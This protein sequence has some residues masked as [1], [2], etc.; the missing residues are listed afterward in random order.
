[1]NVS[2]ELQRIKQEVSLETYVNNHLPKDKHGKPVCPY[3]SSGKSGKANSDSAFS[4]MPS[5]DRFKCFS[6]ET[7]GDIYDLVAQVEHIDVN[8][9]R[10]QLEAI[11]REFNIPLENNSS[12]SVVKPKAPKTQVPQQQPTPT[13][14]TQGRNK[15]HDH[16]QTCI[17]N[18][19]TGKYPEAYEY[20]QGRGFNPE[21]C[22]GLIGYDPRKKSMVIP[23]GD[24]SYYYVERYLYPEQ[25]NGQKHSKPS[26]SLVGEQPI[27]NAK[28]ISEKQPQTL[29]LV[30]G[31]FD[32]LSLLALGHENVICLGGVNNKEKVIKFISELP[33]VPGVL[34]TLDNDDTGTKHTAEAIEQLTEL[35]IPYKVVDYSFIGAKDPNEAFIVNENALSSALIESKTQLLA[36]LNKTTEELLT[37]ALEGLCVST[38]H[39][40]LERILTLGDIDTPIPTGFPSLDEVLDGGLVR[41]LY[42]LGALSS[43][44]KT[45]LLVQIADNIARQGRPVLF[46]TIE[47]SAREIILK[48]LSRLLSSQGVVK[49]GTEINRLKTRYEF[50]DEENRA[51]EEA[52]NTYYQKIAPYMNVLEPRAKVTVKQPQEV[53][54]PDN[55]SIE[56]ALSLLAKKYEVAPVVFVD[57]LQLLAK[58]DPRMIDKEAIDLNV[59]ALRRLAKDYKTPVVVISSLN[60]QNYTKSVNQ[61]AMSGSAGI[62]YGADVLLGLQ[63][64]G[65]GKLSS[66]YEITKAIE[67]ARNETNKQL[68]IKVLKNRNGGLLNT[69]IP[70]VL[71]GRESRFEEGESIYGVKYANKEK[72]DKKEKERAELEAVKQ[73]IESITRK[74]AV[75]LER[76]IVDLTEL[77]R[78]TVNRLLLSSDVFVQNGKGWQLKQLPKQE[79]IDV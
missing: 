11:A 61:G 70:L 76:D 58:D 44:G 10:A 43:L 78:R 73:A 48:S 72:A 15:A 51:F 22:K 37:T 56:E 30:E 75:A 35:V 38:P 36:E 24:S 65:I 39:N 33:Y 47:Q 2:N 29:F 1:M 3:C 79:E 52:Y 49:T 16:M 63:P 27:Y 60:R 23:W 26:R 32:A 5:K 8:N 54:N 21:T 40:E 13:D 67:E 57:Y 18:Y 68:E 41:G 25:H 6:C 4:I 69:P 66:E 20:M 14:Y 45:S 17:A 74:K 34:L 59:T 9:K 19:A 64:R 42:I 46:V 62:E 53:T 7:E 77:S 71:Y 12:L 31:V 50:T 28:T 55:T